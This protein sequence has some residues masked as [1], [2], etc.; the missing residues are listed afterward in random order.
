[1]LL[2]EKS[3]ISAIVNSALMLLVGRQE[4]YVRLVND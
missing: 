4:E 3:G 1:M 2:I